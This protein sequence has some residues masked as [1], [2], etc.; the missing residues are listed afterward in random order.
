MTNSPHQNIVAFHADT[1][2]MSCLDCSA[3]ERCLPAG[4]CDGDA[5]RIDRLVLQR[6]RFLR[7]E[8]LHHMNEPVRGRL[9]AIRSG[10]FK[11]YQ[12]SPGGEQR[13]TGLPASGDLLGLD[14]IGQEL[15]AT[16]AS[17]MRDSTLCEFSHPRLV[18][19]ARHFP[20]LERRLE[21]MLSKE[22]ARQQGVTLLL[23]YHGAEQKFAYFLLQMAW[24]SAQ[25]DGASVL[26]EL[27]LSRQDVGDYLGLTDATITRLLR[28]FQRLGLL[29]VQRRRVS[30]ID[31][32]RLR[33][34]VEGRH[35]VAPG[36]ASVASG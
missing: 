6:H 25:R 26:L 3:R 1:Q 24:A 34:I 7:G 36:A 13:I 23:S 2:S 21:H 31:M 11:C 5:V 19:A 18:E 17:A 14:V 8:T 15:H 16:A 30:L 27:P 4:M 33:Q 9:Y 28:R 12:L 22:L 20:A 10:H 32:H 35:D 29:H